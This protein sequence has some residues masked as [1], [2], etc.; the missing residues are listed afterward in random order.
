LVSEKQ[1][2]IETRVDGKI[3]RDTDR[4][5]DS[6]L[7]GDPE[8]TFSMAQKAVIRDMRARRVLD[9]KHGGT[10]FANGKFVLERLAGFNVDPE[11]L[12]IVS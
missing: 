8:V 7:I 11:T 9:T 4:I 5:C 1:N 12:E 2:L 6:Y 3:F 10:F